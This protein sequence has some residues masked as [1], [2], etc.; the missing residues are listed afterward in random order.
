MELPNTTRANVTVEETSGLL[1]IA[2][3]RLDSYSTNS[4]T[5]SISGGRLNISIVSTA[6]DCVSLAETL[7]YL[8]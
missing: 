3:C 4:S 5:N 2:Q 1:V 6:E 7:I 8:K